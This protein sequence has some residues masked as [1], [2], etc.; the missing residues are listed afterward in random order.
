[1]FIYLALKAQIT[2]LLV[3]KITILNEY[4]ELA[5]LILKK[6]DAKLSKCFNINKYI[7]NLK[8]DKQLFY[9][10]I[11]S[12]VTIGLKILKIYININLANNI[13]YFFKSFIRISILFV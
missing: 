8:L 9:G 13:I 11:Y 7:I 3:K 12:L 5:N 10:S 2:L 1:M 6:S 4:L